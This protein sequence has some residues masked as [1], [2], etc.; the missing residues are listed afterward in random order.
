MLNPASD[1]P[2][3][4]SHWGCIGW[5]AGIVSAI[6]F[7]SLGYAWFR[8]DLN[9][10]RE[11]PEAARV[12]EAQSRMPFQIFIPAYLPADFDRKKV[13]I[14]TDQLSPQ[15]EAMVRLIYPTSQGV[16]L[17]LTEW[18]PRNLAPTDS[19]RQPFEGTAQNVQSCTC[20]CQDHN[21]C[22][23]NHVVTQVGTLRVMAETTNWQVLPRSQ[24]QTILST[25]GPASGLQTFSSLE[26][27]PLSY[28]VPPAVQVPVNEQGIQE[29]VLVVSASGY[30]P[31]HFAVKK[32]MPVRLIFRQLGQVGCG[33]ELSIQWGPQRQAHLILTS[34]TAKQVIEFTPQQVGDYPFHC[35][36]KIYQGVM[37][38]Q[39]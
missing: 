6:A 8:A 19:T 10:P 16:R 36:H 14:Q 32:D 9:Q 13:E 2:R 29:I 12:L 7:L 38:V 11:A 26:E 28:T 24:V 1:R 27:V 33:N 3:T 25:L 23:L 22:N 37:T 18:I 39:E 4:E 35:P 34:P 20:L 31:V 21:V 17:T 30:S 5:L 15:G